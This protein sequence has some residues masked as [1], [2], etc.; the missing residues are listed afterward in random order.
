MMKIFTFGLAALVSLGMI[1]ANA[2]THNELGKSHIYDI[3][4]WTFLFIVFLICTGYVA[5]NKLFK[6]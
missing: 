1:I 6:S 2:Y 5:L 3:A 4:I